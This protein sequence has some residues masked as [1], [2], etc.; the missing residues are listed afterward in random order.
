LQAEDAPTY[1]KTDPLGI[2]VS[3]FNEIHGTMPL[4]STKEQTKLVRVMGDEQM[5]QWRRSEAPNVLLVNGNSG[6]SSG[7]TATLVSEGFRPHQ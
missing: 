6:S 7:S 2:A 1:C 5:L 4:L 3:D